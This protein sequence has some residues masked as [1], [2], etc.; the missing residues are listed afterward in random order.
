MYIYYDIYI[1]V[2]MIYY[3]ICIYIYVHYYIYYYIYISIMYPIMTIFYRVKSTHRHF[4]SYPILS[5]SLSR[6]TIQSLEST[7]QELM[8]WPRES[9]SADLALGK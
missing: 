1:C 5:A 6:V 8:V 2:C 4:R 7:G 3:T 9:T